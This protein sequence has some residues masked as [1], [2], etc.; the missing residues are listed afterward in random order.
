LPLAALPSFH[1]PLELDAAERRRYGADVGFLGA[2]YPNRRV[3]FRQLIGFDF[4]IWGSDWEGD[5]VLA[6]LLQAGGARIEPEEAVKIFNATRVNLNLHSSVRADKLISHGDFVNPRTFELAACGAFQLADRRAL[7][8]ELFAEG[9]LALFTSMEELRAGL[10]HYLAHPD[11]RAAV[12][13]K[14]RAR[15]LAD[16]TYQRRMRDLLDAIRAVRPG[17]PAPRRR[18]VLPAD[19]PD[20]LRREIEALL[21]TLNLPA[22]VDFA[23]L[24]TRLRQQSGRLNSLETSLLFLDEWRKQYVKRA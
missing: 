22:D 4:K 13:A 20:D 18:L 7:M 3:A 2:G 8:P 11:E 19:T 17:W 16:H 23:D 15:V 5:S 10:D 1:R 24:I 21:T 12:A 9:E 6:P 14:G